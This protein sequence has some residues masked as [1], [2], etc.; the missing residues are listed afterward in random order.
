MRTSDSAAG[1][2]AVVRLW[3]ETTALTTSSCGGCE[4][5]HR[6]PVLTVLLPS[7]CL[8]FPR[9]QAALEQSVQAGAHR[10][11]TFLV[12]YC[13]PGR[14]LSYALT[15]RGLTHLEPGWRCGGSPGPLC[16]ELLPKTEL[17]LDPTGLGRPCAICGGVSGAVGKLRGSILSYVQYLCYFLDE[18]FPKHLFMQ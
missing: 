1:A 13:Q 2:A 12:E 14:G 6:G 11:G 18:Y 15:A 4:R 7:A 3:A 16:L 17:G 8:P 9:P 5:A 10:V